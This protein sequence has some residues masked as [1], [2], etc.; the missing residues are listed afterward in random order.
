[1]HRATVRTGPQPH[2]GV[3]TCTYAYDL[4]HFLLQRVV[5]LYRAQ[6]VDQPSLNPS[7]QFDVISECQLPHPVPAV[8]TLPTRAYLKQEEQE[9]TET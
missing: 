1:M 9:W 8:H 7:I 6:K 4:F 2:A 5:Q 3:C